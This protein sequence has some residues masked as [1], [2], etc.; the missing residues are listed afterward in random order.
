M[1]NFVQITPENINK[2]KSLSDLFNSIPD[3][4]VN[5]CIDAGYRELKE[6][7][8]LLPDKTKNLLRQGLKEILK[9][10]DGETQQTAKTDPGEQ[11]T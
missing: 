6:A 8:S 9:D 11:E 1:K 2:I 7:F 10:I 3:I 4:M 5:I